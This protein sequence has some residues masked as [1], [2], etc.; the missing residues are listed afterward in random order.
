M[1]LTV[2]AGNGRECK[3]ALIRKHTDEGR[4]LARARHLYG[5]PRPKLKPYEAETAHKLI[6]E[7]Q[8]AASDVAMQYGVHKTTLYRLMASAQRRKLAQ[9]QPDA[10]HGLQTEKARGFPHAF[11]ST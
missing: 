2:F 6:T 4:K 9:R 8:A 5:S 1:I 11:S 7:E 10:L 3:R